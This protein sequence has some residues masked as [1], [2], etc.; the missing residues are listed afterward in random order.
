MTVSCDDGEQADETLH[1]CNAACCVAYYDR[2]IGVDHLLTMA[3][4]AQAK[5]T[6]VES[7]K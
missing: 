2:R 1:F 5:R 7:A 3:K 4:K 6:K